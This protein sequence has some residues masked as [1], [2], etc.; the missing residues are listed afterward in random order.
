MPTRFEKQMRATSQNYCKVAE[1][2]AAKRTLVMRYLGLKWDLCL[3]TANGCKLTK[4]RTRV[5]SDAVNNTASRWPAR[6]ILNCRMIPRRFVGLAARGFVTCVN[7]SSCSASSNA[8][9]DWALH[10]HPTERACPVVGDMLSLS[11]W[12]K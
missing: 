5:G 12:P 8:A 1:L 10:K 2:K 4:K 11:I 3:P 9:A 7:D 6:R